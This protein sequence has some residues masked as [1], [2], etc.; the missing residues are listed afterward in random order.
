[1]LA[2]DDASLAEARAKAERRY[3]G[4]SW[5]LEAG[6]Y[7]GTP[8]MVVERIQEACAQGISFFVFFTHD[9]ADPATLH[10]L[11]DEVLPAFA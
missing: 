9:R 6:G 8:A 11:A 1:M 7:V 4:P 5:G 3:P 10:L 2:K